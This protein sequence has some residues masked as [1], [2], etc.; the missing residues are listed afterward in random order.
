MSHLASVASLSIVSSLSVIPA[1][2][3]H[4]LLLGTHDGSFHCDEALALA[5]LT[6]LPEYQKATILRSRNPELLAACR[7]VVDVGAVYDPDNHRYDHH[8]KEFTGTFDDKHSIKLSSAG[9][10]YKH[11]GRRIVQSIL[12]ASALDKAYDE[13]LVEICFQKIYNNFIQHIDGI[14]ASLPC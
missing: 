10:V 1:N 5:M 8:Q 3:P 9:L 2:A 4:P 11:F 7:V 13:T 6:L 12:S 14:G